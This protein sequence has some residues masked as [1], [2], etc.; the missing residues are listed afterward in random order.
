[1]SDPELQWCC[2]RCNCKDLDDKADDSLC[3]DEE[4]AECEVTLYSGVDGTGTA[5]GSFP[6]GEYTAGDGFTNDGIRSLSVTATGLDDT[7]RCRIRLTQHSLYGNTG[8]VVNSDVYGDGTTINNDPNT[9]G[10]LSAF[11]VTISDQTVCEGHYGTGGDEATISDEDLQWC[12]YTCNCKDLSDKAD[13]W[14]CEYEEC[15]APATFVWEELITSA[16]DKPSVTHELEIDATSLTLSIHVEADYLGKTTADNNGEVYGTT[17]VI[18]FEDFN[19]HSDSIKTPGTCQ[20]RDVVDFA[21]VTDWA[22]VWK[23]AEIP[24]EFDSVGTVDYLAYAPGGAWNVELV[25]EDVCTVKYSAS[26]TWDELMGC[27]D[28]SGNTPYI[29]STDNE[30]DIT[31]SGTIYVNVVSPFDYKVDYGFYRVYQLISQP[32]QIVI[33]KTVYVLG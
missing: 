19:A 11:A 32:F 23:L 13:D 33:S 1:M 16:T 2:N 21:S 4:D 27:T 30:N 29:T 8:T 9:V 12:C 24:N 20:N 14:L 3:V 15:S 25:E 26:F 18:D 28:S 22:E 6:V 7:T 5:Y 31:L 17:Y 10:G